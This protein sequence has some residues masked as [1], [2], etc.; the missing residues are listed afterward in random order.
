[1]KETIEKAIKILAEKITT[2]VQSDDAMRY[3][4]AALNLEHVLQVKNQ[5][6][7]EVERPL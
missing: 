2:D 1:M 5:L 6:R 7:P 4:Q 3:A